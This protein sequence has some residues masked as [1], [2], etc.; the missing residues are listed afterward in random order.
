MSYLREKKAAPSLGFGVK[1]MKQTEMM[2]S[3]K[4]GPRRKKKGGY[5]GIRAKPP[6]MMKANRKGRR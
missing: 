3:G 2:M 5:G 1:G 4:A 6:V